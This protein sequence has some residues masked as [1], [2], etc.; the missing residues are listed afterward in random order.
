MISQ[1]NEYTEHTKHCEGVPLGVK[2]VVPDTWRCLCETQWGLG[3]S[4]LW[5][6]ERMWPDP[7]ML[8]RPVQ[9]SSISHP[10]WGTPFL[11]PDRWRLSD[12]SWYW[13]WR[14][15]CDQMIC[16]ILDPLT[17]IFKWTN[18]RSLQ[19]YISLWLNYLLVKLW[20]CCDD[21]TLTKKVQQIKQSKCFND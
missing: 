2:P 3:N 21:F 13:K 17:A 8:R 11:D 20:I 14:Y 15:G 5:T 19:R 4:S 18:C 9:T 6:Q 12:C 7:T 10:D 16:I 1:T